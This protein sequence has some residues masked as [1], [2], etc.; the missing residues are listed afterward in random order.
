MDGIFEKFVEEKGLVILNTGK[1]F[2]YSFASGTLTAIDL[3][4]TTAE[5]ALELRWHVVNDLHN[6]DYNPIITSVDT[7]KSF[8]S[9]KKTIGVRDSIL[10]Q[11][12]K[13]DK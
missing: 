10:G 1:M 9:L 11:I 13:V 5:L 6:N 8:P 12:Q 2:H 3:T 7:S 4:V